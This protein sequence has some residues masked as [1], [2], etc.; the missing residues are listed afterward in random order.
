M[1]LQR[2]DHA[3]A[4][5]YA[6][7]AAQASPNNPKLWF[8][9]GYCARLNSRLK[10][11]ESAYTHG[12]RLAPSAPEGLS[13][14]AQ[15]YSLMGRAEEAETLLK[16]VI[17]ASPGGRDDMVL[18]GELY[19][20][21][22]N[23]DGALEWLQKAEALRPDFRSELLLASAF[24]HMKNMEMSG[25]YLAMAKQKA[26]DNPEMLRS[27][28]GYY[29]DIGDDAGAIAAL[30]AIHNPSASV[31]AELAY[32]YQLKGDLDSAAN[33]YAKAASALPGDVGLQLSAAQAEVALGATD[34]AQPFLARA[35]AIAPD[36]YRLHAIRAEIFRIDDRDKDA[37]QEYAIAVANLPAVPVEGPLYGIQ[38]HINMMELLSS[39]L[40]S[41]EAHHQL[42]VAQQEI[43]ALGEPVA[44]RPDFLRLR[45]L[46]HL[47]ANEFQAA[48]RD[49]SEGLALRPNDRNSL[50]LEGD[51]LMKL[52]RSEDAIAAYSQILK[53]SPDNQ[54]AL[55]SIGYASRAVGRD[56]DAERYFVRLAAAHP[57]LYVPYLA[58]GDLY[59]ARRE[60]PS[61]QAS[62]ANAYASAPRR[63][64]IVAGGINAAIEAHDL[65]AAAAWFDRV[66]PPMLQE[67]QI[68]REEERYLSFKG[69]YLGSAEMGRK[70]IAV[71]PHDRDV[72]VY[73]GYDLLHLSQFDELLVLTAQYTS[74][75]PKE[76]DI[77]LLAGYVHKHQGQSEQAIADFTE[78]L[79]RNP[80]VVT[81]YINRGYVLNDTHQ[82]AKAAEDFQSALTREPHNG[83]AHLGMA[84]AELDL[85]EPTKALEQAALAE[86]AL[87]DSR[88]IHVIRATAY[89]RENMLPEAEREYRSALV[90][91][92][93]DGSL[94]LGLGNA[95]FAQSRF[96]E[97]IAE[98]QHAVEDSPESG[99]AYA[100]LARA[101][102]SVQDRPNTLKYVGLAEQRAV[103]SPADEDGGSTLQGSIYLATG[104]ALSTLG[105]RD[106]AMERFRKSLVSAGS[107]RASVRIAIAHIMAAQGHTDDAERQ[108]AL[109]Q[110]E[111]AAG[112]IRPFSAGQLLETADL[113]RSL[114]EYQLAES[115]LQRASAAGAQD[116]DVRV[117]L[118]K[119]LLDLGDT[120]R[121]EAELSAVQEDAGHPHS[122]E[123]LLVQ[124]TLFRK[125]HHDEQALTS[126]A[127]A[128][129]SEGDNRSIQKSML[130]TGAEEGLRVTRK[131]SVLSDFS[132]EPIFEDS[133]VYVLDSKLDGGSATEA[134]PSAG[135]PP[136]RSS[137]QTQWTN[138]LHLHL[139]HLPVA[140]GSFEVRNARGQ[141]SVPSTNSI[142]SRNTTDYSVNAAMTPVLAFRNNV[143]VLNGGI[144]ETIR[145]DSKSPVAMDQ[146]L[147]RAFAYL[148]TSSF[149]N[150]VSVTGY[151]MRDAG[152]FTESNLH[153][154][155]LAG[156]LD[157][158]VGA[159]W[160]KTTLVTG[161]GANKLT[162][163][164]VHYENFVTSS[165]IGLER[166]FGEQLKVRA[167]AEDVRAW[168]V[169]GTASAIAQNLRPAA[170]I[171]W[172]PNLQ[173]NLQASSAYSSTRG[174]HSYDVIQSGFSV[175]YAR[176]FRRRFR[177]DSGSVVIEY[178]IRFSAGV[179]QESFFNFT[180]GKSQ[181]LEPYIRISL[182]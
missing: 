46:I 152:P 57:D 162:L 94:H 149:F 32:T 160:S 78:A 4:F 16:Q 105:D 3:Q 23:Y 131:L 95:L 137:L 44:G 97:A 81:A 124:A 130:E 54:F 31:L 107:D 112:G 79:R 118:A 80:E 163:S 132:L 154:Q 11:S 76:A 113:F 40:E 10:E 144:Q 176:P 121:A 161:W 14:L 73:L 1:A 150:A 83:E 8:L 64:L 178:P 174:F 129:Q 126:F 47:H 172:S 168:R 143:V 109:A 25:R 106:A 165:Y 170:N 103:L 136:P 159:P 102:A 181:T 49:V 90:F 12:L 89:G 19:L 120:Q 15:T 34:K 69:D 21:G 9:L 179:Q 108:I 173:W 60:F 52:G 117:E 138:V 2:G 119:T 146:N 28:A 122:Y 133:T 41:A 104:Q 87:G 77:P 50:Q 6:E 98:L 38:L 67:P 88:D 114:H 48:L 127:Q 53:G 29:R 166:L 115:Y 145:R 65:L 135:L 171:D 71:L 30:S 128:S 151:V 62:Y 156:A 43:A 33:L 20:R 180:G 96:H 26:P 74:I 24:Q 139:N 61:A 155:S 157:F 167:I 56:Q 148:S 100:L 93:H 70:A 59:T 18:L 86:A 5:E 13:G 134:D 51:V 125:Q 55:I 140:T 35:A 66:T 42:E 45:A 36:H 85:H 164:P 72:V 58:L 37:L 153:S 116:A 182:F 92:P 27:M 123:F 177:D 158:R 110:I 142:V 91:A 7:R 111:V 17:S 84:Y 169:V 68:L 99:D 75:L 39:M 82:P 147:F 175:S 101:W 22:S 141:I 63:P